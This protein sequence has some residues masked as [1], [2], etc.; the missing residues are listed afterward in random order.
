M[1]IITPAY[2]AMCATEN[3]TASTQSVMKE[4]FKKGAAIVH[5][6]IVGTA[7][8]SELY[9]KHE[10]FHKYRYYMQVVASTGSAAL[11]LEWSGT[12]ESRMQRLAMKLECVDS[13][14]MVHPFTKGFEQV[15]YCISD[16]EAHAVAQGENWESISNRKKEDIEGK[17]GASTVYSTTFYIGLAIAPKASADIGPRRLD[18]SYPMTEFTKLVKMWEKFDEDTMDIAVCQIKSSALPDYVFEEG[19]RRPKFAQR[20]PKT[21][22]AYGKFH[23]TSPDTPNKNRQSSNSTSNAPGTTPLHTNENGIAVIP[24]STNAEPK[25]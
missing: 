8:W 24:P 21:T 6:V 4:E 14:T 18:F 10:F 17:E 5:R 25:P 19:E 20:R 1:P 22:K 11:Q 2:P 9:T 12:V 23:N 13:L 7:Q 15:S 3:V 16:D